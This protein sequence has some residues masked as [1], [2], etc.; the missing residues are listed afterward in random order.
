VPVDEARV[1]AAYMD[2]DADFSVFKR[3]MIL[4]TFVAFQSGWERDQRRGTRGIRI[5]ARD[6]DR[7]KTRVSELFN[8]V[9][10]EVLEADDGYEVVSDLDDDALLCRPYLKGRDW[11]DFNWYVKKQIHPNLP[12]LQAAL[13][14][15]GPWQGEAT[16]ID[17]PWVKSSLVEKITNID[18]NEAAEDVNRFLNAAEQKSLKLWSKR[19]F[20]NKVEKI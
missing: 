17:L 6:I 8:S 16:I 4:D 5:S 13:Y 3:V 1:A 20:L 19:F 7:I 18:W 9:L 10:I 12:H 2:P 14:Q 11:Y 15:L